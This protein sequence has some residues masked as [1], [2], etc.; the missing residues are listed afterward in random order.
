MEFQT[1]SP[2]AV[3]VSYQPD[4]FNDLV[5]NLINL[6]RDLE[7]ESKAL[8]LRNSVTD[9]QVKAVIQSG[10]IY[11]GFKSFEAVFNPEE[12]CGDLYYSMVQKTAKGWNLELNYD[13]AKV[14]GQSVAT[15]IFYALLTVANTQTTKTKYKDTFIDE[16]LKTIEVTKDFYEEKKLI[17]GIREKSEHN[18]TSTVTLLT[19]KKLSPDSI[20]LIHQACF[21]SCLM[22]VFCFNMDATRNTF[23]PLKD[24]V[25]I[26]ATTVDLALT[27][28]QAQQL[29][30]T[31]LAQLIGFI[32]NAP[33]NSKEALAKLRKLNRSKGFGS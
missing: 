1:V 33:G 4:E 17:A 23:S 19:S 6:G 8:M 27:D 9:E 13:Q 22:M 20:Y 28:H 2:K 32:H 14:I 3:T 18:F 25:Q 11:L 30:L 5:Y 15:N 7:N 16:T 24:L 21:V 10:T 26:H 12:G 29:S 31:T